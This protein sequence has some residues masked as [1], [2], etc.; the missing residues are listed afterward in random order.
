MAMAG[1]WGRATR[2][3]QRPSLQSPPLS[4]TP[5]TYGCVRWQLSYD[6]GHQDSPFPIEAMELPSP[7]VDL[8]KA[9]R[10]DAGPVIS[11]RLVQSHFAKFLWRLLYAIFFCECIW[12]LISI[13][14]GAVNGLQPYSMILDLLNLPVAVFWRTLKW[15]G[16]RTFYLDFIGHWNYAHYHLMPAFYG[17]MRSGV[18]AYLAFFY[19]TDLAFLGL[20]RLGKRSGPPQGK[21]SKWQPWK[22]ALPIFRWVL[23][24]AT[25]SISIWCVISREP[26]DYGPH[27][28]F[29][30]F[31]KW[32]DFPIAVL[33]LLLPESLRGIDL[34]F[35]PL[36]GLTERDAMLPAHLV[37]GTAIYS[38]VFLL[39]RRVASAVRFSSARPSD[40]GPT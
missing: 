16:I 8:S 2:F 15:F 34:W 22:P 10:V 29:Y 21:P 38:S 36:P 12:I 7:E 13:R 32:V 4:V 37:L 18:L 9:G 20:R 3:T 14:V 1:R 23:L 31:M 17:H 39:L 27:A 6:P 33:S 11:K 40:Q 30:S 35:S 28:V 5:R 25:L 19:A 24:A 26:T